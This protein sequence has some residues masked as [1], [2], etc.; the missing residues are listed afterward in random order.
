MHERNALIVKI[1]SDA[2]LVGWGETANI[3]GARAVIEQELA[4]RLIGENPLEVRRLWHQNWGANF[5]HSFAVS[6]IDIALHDLR[7]RLLKLSIGELYGG[8]FR[9]RVVAYA[10]GV[11][12]EVDREPE[13]YWVEEAIR[14]VER[15]FRAIKVRI[16]RYPPAREL[17]LLEKMRAAVPSGVVLL[18][19]G[20]AGYTLPT[21]LRVGRELGRLGFGWFEEPITQGDYQGYSQLADQLDIPIAAG[22][23]LQSRSAASEFLNRRSADIIQPDVYIC[24]GIGE[25]L[26]IAELARLARVICL[27]HCFGGGIAL[28]ASAHL[29]SL[30]PDPTA[31]AG[32]EVPLLEVEVPG[33]IF[34]RELLV[35]PLNVEDGFVRVPT[36]P[37]LGV[38]VDED[39]LRAH[40]RE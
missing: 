23:A 40:A 39:V 1:T 8:A 30:V 25:W 14:L 28:A 5:G 18:A 33:T 22:E 3:V 16:G 29:L 20:N 36:G 6:G 32:A 24:G 34:Q 17:P 10:A 11:N 13:E 31:V 7:G 12:Y 9:K 35:T 26:F 19:D 15:G 38:E 37:G 27:P 4:P 2:G 21:A